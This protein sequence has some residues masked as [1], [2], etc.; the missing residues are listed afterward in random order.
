MTLDC[1]AIGG[2]PVAVLNRLE[3]WEAGLILNLRLWCGG[4][5]GQ[6]QVRADY[7]RAL[8]D[9]AADRELATLGTFIQTVIQSAHRP[10]IQHSVGCACVGADEAVLLHLVRTASL[11]HLTDAA[12]ISTLLAGPAQAEHIALLAGQ[13]GECARR[14]PCHALVHPALTA[15]GSARI[16]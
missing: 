14:V 9:T 7:A 4:P 12:L 10:L 11:G 16:H 15:R 13:V 8:S 5:E 3:A 2:A 6:A 1:H